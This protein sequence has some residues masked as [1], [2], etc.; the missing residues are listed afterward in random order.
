MTRR[1]PPP[2][3]S[4]PAV[5][6]S[7]PSTPPPAE[8]GYPAA[9]SRPNRRR[10]WST[11]AAVVAIAAAPVGLSDRPGVPQSEETT[12]RNG[13]TAFM[14]EPAT[15]HRKPN[16][17]LHEKSPYLLQHAYNPV[18][19]YPWGEEAFAKARAEGKP[20][21]LSIG[22]STCHWC[23]VMERESFEDDS[24]AALLNEHFVPIK[25]DR[26]ER[27]D[28]DRLYMTAM[29]AMGMGG[30]WPLNAFL[31]PDLHPFFGGTYFPPRAKMGRPG[32]I[33]ILPRLHDAWTTQR[34]Q[35]EQ[36]GERVMEALG[37]LA[38]PDS[39][40]A[41]R[42]PLFG[43]AAASLARLNDAERGGFGNAP[44]F[45]SIVNLDFLLRYWARDPGKHEHAREMVVA[46]L[47][48]MQAGGIH[49]QIGGGFHRYSTD[50][51]W[52]VPHF[53]KMLY[54]QAQIAWAYL[55]AFQV[56]GRA[57]FAAT[58]RDVFAYV[59]RDLSSPEGGFLSAEDADSEGEEGRFYVW[60]PAQ[61]EE[62]LGP[63]DATLV[64]ERFGVTAAGNFEPGPSI[65]HRA[66]PVEDVA[67]Q[68][69]LDAAACRGR[70]GRA[71]A[72]LLAARSKRVRPHL[73]DKVI[74]AWN[75]LMIAACARGARALDDP[76]LAARAARAAEF[77]WAHLRDP[78][79]GELRRA[80]RGG[81]TGAGQL[82]DY[83]DYAFGLI[84]L[85]SATF[86][87]RWLERAVR[88]TELQ[89]ERFWDDRDGGFFESPAGD[90]YV[91]LRMKDDFDGAEI[92]GNSI[93]AYNLERLAVLLD[94]EDWRRLAGRTL[95]YYARRLRTHPTAM[96]R[97]LVAM[98]LEQ[99]VAR[100]IVIAGKADGEDTHAMIREFDR[101]FLPHDLLLR[102]TPADA[103]A[104]AKLAP[105]AAA[106]PAKD[107]HATAYVCVNYA[108][109]LPAT[110]AA[111]FAAQLAKPR[112]KPLAKG[113]S[114]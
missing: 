48:A 77:V 41:E 103:P 93:A 19:W 54:D 82:D 53:E 24:V 107:G 83:A 80:F 75:G 25:V 21:F 81:P 30:G 29:Q 28:V 98:D 74:T 15:S 20:I 36:A 34:L 18:D 102:V 13:V 40:E 90:P 46:Q 72:A 52:L 105:F 70:I 56:T 43:E 65:L 12:A 1:G 9:P 114:R 110:D 79:T 33:E 32:L 61:L 42:G 22:Y 63:E 73:D 76:A 100:H 2:E 60:T 49:D 55:E 71:K 26:E 6:S 45:P 84:E 106:L 11:L 94:R 62:A 91:K 10:G 86:D 7:P 5:T 51:E 95:D 27:P 47:E 113:V 66:R 68:H 88:V 87:P 14:H 96:P 112:A 44:K 4:S 57:D 69:H 23:H 104:L 35:V 37:G 31:T 97:M 111:A 85:Y 16:R 67:K 99:S 17:L 59:F 101:R 64:A 78:R 3:Y 8:S 39:G 58:A 38:A 108:C 50:R 92:A 89:V 109:E